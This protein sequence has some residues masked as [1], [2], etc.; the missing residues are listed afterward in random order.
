MHGTLPN[1]RDGL[2]DDRACR[3]A[4]RNGSKSFHAASLLLPKDVRRSALA[5]YAFCRV[6]DDLVDD[7]GDR[8]IVR[9]RATDELVD[10]LDRAYAGVP[11]DHA[12]D[13]AFA[14]AVERHAIPYA[15]PFALIEGFRW[16][17][18][19]RRYGTIGELHA[20]GARVASSVGAMMTLAMGVRD[21]VALARACDLGLAMQLT[22]IARDVGEDARNG[23]VYLPLDWL[24][25]VGLD[26]DALIA[27]P[28]FDPRLGA[29]VERLLEEAK[30][31]YD[32]AGTG[33]GALPAPCRTAIRAALSIYSDIGREIT[34]AGFDSV[35]GR[36]FTSR[37]RKLALA[38][39]ASRSRFE[40]A[41]IDP[42]PPM[43][44]VRYLVEA[45]RDHATT[46]AP[47][48]MER[49]LGR[50][51]QLI[52]AMDGR[53]GVDLSARVRCVPGE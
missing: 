9:G 30:R 37:N 14:R 5:L 35:T 20:Y 7:Q 36:A 4:I 11:A 32:R 33:I 26:P 13:R 46:A 41:P 48:P 44:Q 12:A 3:R 21:P 40:N 34:R 42:A 1:P 49:G 8:R 10:R 25:A 28:R 43:P 47:E 31:L 51:M 52:D 27:S 39:A 16:D 17:E 18:A 24:H 22:N 45:V 15:L 53:R 29:V 50:F 6:S 23:R 2:E 19:G 38:A